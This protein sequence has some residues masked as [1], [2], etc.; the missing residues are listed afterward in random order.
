MVEVKGCGRRLSPQLPA[1]LPAQAPRDVYLLRYQGRYVVW[2][3][4]PRDLVNFVSVVLGVSIGARTP[5]PRIC[6]C[7]IM[8]YGSGYRKQERG[9]LDAKLRPTITSKTTRAVHCHCRELFTDN[10]AVPR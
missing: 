4:L 6:I 3:C 10:L 2:R 8:R 1:C 9:T 7:E 5:F